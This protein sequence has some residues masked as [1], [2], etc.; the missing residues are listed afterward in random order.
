VSRSR[1]SHPDLPGDAGLRPSELRGARGPYVGTPSARLERFARHAALEDL[2]QELYAGF[3]PQH[4]WPAASPFE[5]VVGAVLTQNTSWR[6]VEN[7]LGAL[8]RE[9]RL[10]PGRLLDLD[11]SE[12][13]ELVR[14]SGT[15]RMKARKLHAVSRWYLDVGG[16]DALRERPLEPLRDELLGVFGVGPETADGILC[17]AAGRRTPVV[18]AYTRRILGRHAL[19]PEDTPYEVVRRW[20]REV[21]VD[22]QLVYEEFHALCVR[23]GSS[24]CKPKPDCES[25]PATRPR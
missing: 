22:S 13:A 10:T 11:A 20:L 19:L 23:A 3:G 1:D 24:H 8:R 5:V 25:C 18:D 4:W 6:N 12:L 17:Y 21:L 15:F 14:P 2:A 16:L 7:A 9:A